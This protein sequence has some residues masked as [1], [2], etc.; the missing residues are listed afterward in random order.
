MIHSALCPH[1]GVCGGC[2]TQDQ[3]Y[4]QQLAAKEAMVRR[5][6]QPFPIPTFLPIVPSPDE[7]FYRNKMEFSFSSERWLTAN[8]IAV[9]SITANEILAG[10]ITGNEIAAATITAREAA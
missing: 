1:F 6:L 8:E 10:T 9:R 4:A 7:F 5:V 3:P 2:A